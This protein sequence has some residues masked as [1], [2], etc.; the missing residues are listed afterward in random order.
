[1]PLACS[2][3]RPPRIGSRASATPTRSSPGGDVNAQA[4]ATRIS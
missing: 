3:A 1:M 4:D 2:W